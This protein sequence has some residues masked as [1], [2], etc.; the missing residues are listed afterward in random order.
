M[1]PLQ[2]F[3][4]SLRVIGRPLPYLA[5]DVW[6]I[7]RT[8]DELTLGYNI[9]YSY[10]SVNWET[11]IDGIVTTGNTTD[12]QIVINTDNI[13]RSFKRGFKDQQQAN[14]KDHFQNG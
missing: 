9:G 14:P 5:P 10:E 12:A 6:V 7:S 2:A 8:S 11:L 13:S 1:N 4:Y 3:N